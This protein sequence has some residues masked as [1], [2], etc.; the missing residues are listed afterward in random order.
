MAAP[1]IKIVDVVK[2]FDG[3]KVLD[4][5][6]LDILAGKI[7]FII[8]RSG[9]G[10]SV[11][12]KILTGLYQPDSGSIFYGDKNLTTARTKDWN[13]LRRKMGLLFQDGALFDSMSL[14]E[15]VCFPLWFHHLASPS[16]ARKRAKTLLGE[17]GLAE[18]FFS[19]ISSLST[20]ER[21]RVA[22]ARALIMEPEIVFF[23]EPTTGL[24]PILSSQVDE[25]IVH[26][27]KKTGATVIVVSHD[28]AATLTLADTVTL[29]HQGVVVFNGTPK[30]L[31]QSDEPEIK[32]FLSAVNL[33]N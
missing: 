10:K 26:A 12:M 7:N 32:L 11:L 30:Q 31:S 14:G 6:S 19:P 22:L 17:L 13:A 23:D 4:G 33:E 20:G 8:G 16:E 15:N 27:Q 21:K 9:E 28:M 18:A 2:T 5:V 25:L 24:D 3:D 29:L 1:S